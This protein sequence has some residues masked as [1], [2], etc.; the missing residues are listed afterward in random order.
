MGIFRQTVWSCV[1]N[2]NNSKY[3]YKLAIGDATNQFEDGFNDDLLDSYMLKYFKNFW[4]S[5]KHHLWRTSS[6]TIVNELPLLL[7]IT[8]TNMKLKCR[9]LLDRQYRWYFLNLILFTCLLLSCWKI[10][11]CLNIL[12]YITCIHF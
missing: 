6:L 2:E 12:F 7:W 11:C 4:H 9:S 3:K 5:W 8:T 1:W 10:K